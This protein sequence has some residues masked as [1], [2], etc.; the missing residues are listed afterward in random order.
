MNQ[1]GSG[2]KNGKEDYTINIMLAAGA[3]IFKR[4]MNKWKSS[5]WRFLSDGIS[6]LSNRIIYPFIIKKHLH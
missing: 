1:V 4:M 6:Q 2:R 3:F 5:F